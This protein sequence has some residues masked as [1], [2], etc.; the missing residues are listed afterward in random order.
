MCTEANRART[1]DRPCHAV[2]AGTRARPFRNQS[3]RLAIYEQLDEIIFTDDT[4]S[5][6]PL[7]AELLRWLLASLPLV[8]VVPV[9]AVVPVAVPVEE[10]PVEVPVEEVPVEP[11]LCDASASRPVT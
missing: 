6:G 3:P 9:V 4:S 10:V 2:R 7:L 5:F 8:P 1:P 11:M